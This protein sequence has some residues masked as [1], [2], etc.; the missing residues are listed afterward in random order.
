[1][2][3]PTTLATW[4]AAIADAL[5]ARGCDASQ[6][7]TR[8]GLDPGKLAEPGARYPLRGMT[9]LWNLAIAASGDPA[10]ALEVPHHV[11]PG[12][13]HA[14]GHSL[15]ASSHLLDALLRMARYS[16]LVTDAADIAIELDRE[17]ICLVYRPPAHDIPLA[18]A[19]YE[20]FM[21]TAVN[22]GR[23]M[24]GPQHGLL[25]CEFR[26][27]APADTSPYARFFACPVRFDA[28]QNRLIFDRRLLQR[29]LPGANARAAQRFDTA[30]AAYLARFDAHPAS[31]R[32]RELLIQRLPSG[33]PSR[34]AIADALHLTPRTLLRRLA[35]EGTHWKALLNDTRRELALSYLRQGRSGAE[36]TYLLGFADP[37]NF[38]RAF[39]RWQ[40]CSP[41]AWLRTRGSGSGSGSE[42]APP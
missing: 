38:T 33:E 35:G 7:L 28:Q 14:L 32:V 36:I 4:A 13:M 19:A 17:Q 9:Q 40:K 5:R 18:N 26:H 29:P 6:L 22:L 24:A 23:G 25:G 37:S 15:R 11:R 39:K 16:R 27:A 3:E 34:K 12:T 10:F 2:S 41:Q 21:A 8:A 1:M 20:A 31:Q 42:P 30:A